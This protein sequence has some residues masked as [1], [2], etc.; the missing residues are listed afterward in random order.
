MSKKL[1]SDIMLL[2]TAII[3]G[4]AFV[5]QKA[6]TVLDPFTYNGIRNI[7]GAL[8]LVPV[9]LIFSKGKDK[10]DPKTY[11]Q[12][13]AENKILIKGGICCGLALGIAS[14]LQQYG[15][16]FDTDAGK[17]GFITTLYIV[18]VPILGLFLGKRVR[19][20]I[21]VCVALGVVGF[22]FL[23]MAGSDAGLALSKGDLFVLL[24]AFAFSCHI[25][26][27]DHFSPKCDGIKLSCIQFLT[28]GII[29][30]ICMFLFEDPDI[31][32]ILDCWGPIL[33]VGVFSSGVAYTLQV[34][35][36][37]D[38][39]PTTASL[40]L[41]LESVFAVITGMIFANETMTMF[42][43]LGCVIIFVAVIVAQLPS[44]EEK[45]NARR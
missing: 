7:V 27:I 30:C 2:I 11:A 18:I 6:G 32:E 37:K 16:F 14:T 45:L 12:K 24:C 29:C 13:K 41:S 33:Y 17:A 15:L 40:I 9:I 23:T 4:S 39:E 19:P 35:A 43:V 10:S 31:H 8:V 20:V 3:W 34:V 5:A 38:A 26:V 21:W 42:E 28:A 1:R 44:K 36:Q 25:L 22:Y